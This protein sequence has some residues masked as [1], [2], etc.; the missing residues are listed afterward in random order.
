[1]AGVVL[2]LNAGSSSLKTALY[3]FSEKGERLLAR[4]GVESIGSPDARL[5]LA[6]SEGN[7]LASK[8]VGSINLMAAL[9]GTLGALAEFGFPKHEAIGHRVVHGGAHYS[10]PQLVT[11]D[12]L[13]RLRT[14]VPLAPLHLEHELELIEFA[15]CRDDRVPQVACFD[16]AFF[17]EMPPTARHLPLPEVLWDEGVRRYGFHGISYEYIVAKLGADAPSRMIIAHLGSGAS[18]AA[19][20]DGRAVDT[21]M[22]MTPAGGLMMSTRPGDLDP[23]VMLYLLRNKRYTVDALERVI[24]HESGLLGVSGLTGDMRELLELAPTQA[25]AAQAV[26]MYCWNARKHVGALAASLGGLDALVFTGGVGER[27]PA[28]REKICDGLSHLG[29]QLDHTANHSGRETISASGS[30]CSLMAVPTNEE[31]MIARHAFQAVG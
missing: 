6:T 23:G 30:R 12:V 5:T 3:E 20:R 8:R 22:G 13:Q 19:V 4:A 7:P 14:L 28:V 2:A 16:T 31:L 24:N 17:C 15:A 10:H 18:M 11:E 9:E 26:E 27:A 1:M 29:V 21:T 25:R